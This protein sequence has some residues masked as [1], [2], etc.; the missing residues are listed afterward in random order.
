MNVEALRIGMRVAHPAYGSGTVCAVSRQ[1]CDIE[2]DDGTKRTVSPHESR[3][4]PAEPQA[5]VTGVT[6]PLRQVVRMIVQNTLEDLGV[7]DPRATVDLLGSRWR[8]GTLRIVPLDDSLQAKEIPVETFFHKIVMMRNQLRVLEQKINS[9]KGLEEEEK[10]D[11]QQYISRCYG[12]MTTF[13]TLFAE[14]SDQFRASN[15]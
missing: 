4:E 5:E 6:R 7:D 3:I 2:F 14:K 9:H 8:K 15:S 1:T 11:M 12:S 10:I 13:N